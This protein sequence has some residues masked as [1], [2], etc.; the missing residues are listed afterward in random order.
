MKQKNLKYLLIFFSFSIIL[1]ACEK[2]TKFLKPETSEI[3][4][5]IFEFND[6]NLKNNETLIKNDSIFNEVSEI[7]IEKPT[8]KK[9]T[10]KVK[11]GDNLSFILD[12][13]GITQAEIIKLA[14]IKYEGINFNSIQI[15]QKYELIIDEISNKLISYV[16]YFSNNNVYNVNFNP[17][18]VEKIN[19]VNSNSNDKIS[20]IDNESNNLITK[21]FL[22]GKISFSSNKKF[23]KLEKKFHTKSEMFLEK[24]T[25]DA[26][27]RMYFAAK[28]DGINLIIVSGARNYYAQKSIWERKFKKNEEAGMSPIDNAYKIL[29]YSSMP[30]TSRHHWG[31]DIDINNLEPE[32]FE[33]GIGKIEYEWLVTNASK[34]GFCQV[35]SDF[36]KNDR[37]SGYQEEAWHW[38]YT[39]Q[40]KR[41]L[42]EYNKII[43]HQ[44]INGFIGSDLAEKLGMIENYVN[45]ISS[46]CRLD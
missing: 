22:L 37:S 41:F 18:K 46:D 39:P 4:K 1:L 38:T 33:S 6:S 16:H 9:L 3:P 24:Q 26:F 31:T 5:N 10:L 21:S 7:K 29:L 44:D 28:E 8:L 34:F 40:S 43:R 17:L 45:G 19:P 14:N 32:Y 23:I 30:S 42:D 35:Y 2:K 20:I 25:A 13:R 27:K 12:K 36:S 11:P 15:G